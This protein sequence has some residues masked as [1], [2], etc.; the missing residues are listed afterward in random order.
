MKTFAPLLALFLALSAAAQDDVV[1]LKNGSVQRG[2]ILRVDD[3]GVELQISKHNTIFYEY[4]VLNP[5][6]AYSIRRSRIDPGN[7]K[8]HVELARFCKRL[9]LPSRAIDHF[10]KAMDLDPSLK[11]DLE[12]EIKDLR[13]AEAARLYRSAKAIID[14]E[15]EDEYEDAAGA[16]HEIL[17]KY[18]DTP[19]GEEARKL[20]DRLADKIRE[21]AERRRKEKERKQKAERSRQYRRQIEEP[22]RRIEKDLEGIPE[23]WG[24]GLDYEASGSALRAVQAWQGAEQKLLKIGLS[25]QELRKKA[26]DALVTQRL[27]LLALQTNRWKVRVYLSLARIYA[28]DQLDYLGSLRW[29]NKAL[30]LDP[31]NEPAWS[32]KLMVSEAVLK[33][34]LRQG[35]GPGK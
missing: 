23:I 17:D 9:G 6:S 28:V 29:I 27:D 14:Q 1:Q 3:R 32:L 8:D 11:S 35:G 18:Y 4:K 5:N 10:R 22:L 15:R 30:K 21:R 13:T 2:K 31:D 19:Y 7:P 24:S 34:R 25:I 33:S 16:I 12:K 26:G 20:D